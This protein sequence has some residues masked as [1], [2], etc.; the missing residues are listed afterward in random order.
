MQVRSKSYRR[1]WADSKRILQRDDPALV[2]VRSLLWDLHLA[3][4]ITRHLYHCSPTP[5]LGHRTRKTVELTR[6]AIAD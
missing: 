1:A 6:L 3:L 4:D 2:A 5:T